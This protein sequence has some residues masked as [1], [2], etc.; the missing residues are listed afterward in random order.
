[1][2][3]WP[4]APRGQGECCQRTFLN[5]HKQELS[6]LTAD[7][8][9]RLSWSELRGRCSW[10]SVQPPRV[11]DGRRENR[12]EENLPGPSPTLERSLTP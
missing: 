12:D 9:G 8:A 4:E 10:E 5:F 3:H 11:G 1:M 6:R 2:V 7:S